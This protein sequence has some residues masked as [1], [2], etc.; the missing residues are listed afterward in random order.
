MKDIR[1]HRKK[2]IF[3]FMAGV[4]GQDLIQEVY[5][6]YEGE[7]LWIHQR[8]SANT[9][10]RTAQLTIEDGDGYQIFDGTAKAANGI[11]NHEFGVSVRRILTGG[12]FLK[13]TISGDPGIGGY[14]VVA[15]VHYLGID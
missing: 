3:V 4:G 7:L 1:Y 12:N 13:C 9:N 5:L 10:N 14:T 2:F 11:Y 15:V 8:N 6:P